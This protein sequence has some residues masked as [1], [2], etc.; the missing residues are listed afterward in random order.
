MIESDWRGSIERVWRRVTTASASFL[1]ERLMA[2]RI[3]RED[4][5]KKTRGEVSMR[6]TA[7]ES[8]REKTILNED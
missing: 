1:E 3:V 7:A 4:D 5:D 8:A 6:I 2:E